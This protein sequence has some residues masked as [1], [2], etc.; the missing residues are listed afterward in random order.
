M[1]LP[2]CCYAFQG[3]ARV[4]KSDHLARP[5]VYLAIHAREHPILSTAE[6]S[7][8]FVEPEPAILKLGVQGAL[9]FMFSLDSHKLAWSKIQHRMW[10]HLRTS[11][12]NKREA[13]APAAA[14]HRVE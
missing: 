11:A 13:Y 14:L 8:L 12:G 6:A 4:R 1:V 3:D 7:H 2:C 5:F 9:D 10:R